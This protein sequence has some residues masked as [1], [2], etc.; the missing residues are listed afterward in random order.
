ML[1]VIAS[2]AKQSESD[3]RGRDR[4]VAPFLVMSLVCLCLFAQP[5][6]AAEASFQLRAAPGRETVVGSCSACHSLDYIAIN[7]PFLT[8][9]Q[10]ETEVSKMIDAYGAPI[11]AADTKSIVDY[12][13]ENYSVRAQ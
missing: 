8:R 13:D 12:L 11:S 7:S 3:G 1:A 6:R 5:A 2:A 9:A 10:W 4:M